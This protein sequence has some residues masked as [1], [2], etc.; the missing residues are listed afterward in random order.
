MPVKPAISSRPAS[1]GDANAALA[2]DVFCYRL[3]QS[4]ASLAVA[5]GRVD[6]L[7]FTGGIGERSATVRARTLDRLAVFG[8]ALDE[9]SNREN[10]ES[11][12]GLI[13]LPGSP[14]VLVVPTNEELLI[15]MDTAEL[16]APR[17]E[18]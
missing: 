18:A 3:A 1:A 6:A 17:P 12:D 7:I 11:R 9:A 8:F 15:A 16:L 5:L 10:G 4:L 2:V 14:P 13:S